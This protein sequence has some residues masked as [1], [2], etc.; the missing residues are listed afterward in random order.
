MKRCIVYFP[1]KIN[2]NHPS[3]SNIRPLKIIEGF[4]DLGYEVDV[5][6]GYG[7]ERKDTLKALRD[8]VNSGEE[9]EF[10]YMESSTEP[11]LLTE[12]KHIPIHPFLDFGFLRFCKKKGIKIGLFYR[13]I[14]WRFDQYKNTVSP[15]KRLVAYI[16]YYYDLL[17]YKRIIDVLFLPSL[18]MKKYIPVELRKPVIELP[19][20][21]EY[22]GY[23]PKKNIS[24][25]KLSI[26]YVG[27]LSKEL[28]NIESL[29]KA[30]Y[31]DENY[32]LD[33]CCREGEW[34]A[35]EH[36][37]E[38]YLNERIKF[39]HKSGNE[40]DKIAMSKDLFSLVVEPSPYWEFAMPMKL[41][42]Y[43]S[44]GKPIIGVDDTACGEFIEKYSLGYLTEYEESKIK[45]TLKYIS[46]NY[47]RDY[48]VK[49]KAIAKAFE[50]NTWKARAMTV[51]ESLLKIQSH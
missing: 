51:A 20:G 6:K 42:S 8:R 25:G 26:L 9:Y 23:R 50:E 30:V 5:I 19:S 21:C 24:D 34:K 1:F 32:T 15:Q 48:E 4:K 14:H 3:A 40:L 10:V 12:A 49:T 16:F 18:K 27:G 43:I 47:Q 35:N 45:E 36:Y 17:K 11:T 39:I 13:D 31:E 33:I 37:Y 38:K 29:V 41:F 28:Y 44:Y 46:E 7:A 2:E 22:I